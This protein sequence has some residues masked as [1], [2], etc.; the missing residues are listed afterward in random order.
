MGRKL[1]REVVLVVIFFMFILFLRI[2]I[3]RYNAVSLTVLVQF[4]QLLRS[5]A[6]L[7]PWFSWLAKVDIFSNRVHCSTEVVPA[8]AVI[9]IIEPRNGDLRSLNS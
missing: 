1:T 5:Q 4:L 7:G 3:L 8:S 9:G 6:E 2:T